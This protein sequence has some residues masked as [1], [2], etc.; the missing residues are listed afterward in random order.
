M[1]IMF[2]VVVVI[3][4]DVELLETTFSCLE[5]FSSRGGS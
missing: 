2:V 1:V 5:I 3:I 4:G